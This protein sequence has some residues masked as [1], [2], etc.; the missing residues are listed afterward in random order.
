VLS[1]SRFDC[2]G[3]PAGAS[4]TGVRNR[5]RTVPVAKTSTPF[6]NEIRAALMVEV[7]EAVGQLL[8]LAFARDRSPKGSN[9]SGNMVTSP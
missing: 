2:E 5:R 8:P 4:S 6:P 1:L 3:A 9:M 7:L